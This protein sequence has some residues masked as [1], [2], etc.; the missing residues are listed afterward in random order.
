[1]ARSAIA[2][3]IGGAWRLVVMDGRGVRRRAV[4]MTTLAAGNGNRGLV[5]LVAG[6]GALG[7]DLVVMQGEIGCRMAGAAT[8]AT[9]FR[10]G[11]QAA[12]AEAT[13]HVDGSGGQGMMLRHPGVRRVT[14]LAAAGGRLELGV[15]RSAVRF[16]AGGRVDV[17]V[18][19]GAIG[20]GPLVMAGCAIACQLRL[21]MTNRAV[22]LAG[23]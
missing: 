21:G 2:A 3:G 8:G 10:S 14:I 23:R 9:L 22:E 7:P 4:Y 11:R 6:Q 16:A 5:A 12:V 19:S 18:V 15:A 1:M 20:R 13:A 17:V